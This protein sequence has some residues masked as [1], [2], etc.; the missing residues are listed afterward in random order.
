M[1]RTS[2]SLHLT[3]S[4]TSTTRALN[5]L[6]AN[7]GAPPEAPRTDEQIQAARQ[8]AL[9]EF[10]VLGL[11]SLLGERP[12][13]PMYVELSPTASHRTVH[14]LIDALPPHGPVPPLSIRG[15]IP[16][17]VD[18]DRLNRLFTHPGLLELSLTDVEL[19]TEVLKDIGKALE[20]NHSA[21][22]TLVWTDDRECL[23]DPPFCHI[24]EQLPALRSLA[25]GCSAAD[26]EPD[27]QDAQNWEDLAT[28][29]LSRPLER[30]G[31]NQCGELMQALW[32]SWPQHRPIAWRSL[33]LSHMD[34]GYAEAVFLPHL[35]RFLCRC[36]ADPGLVELHLNR[37]TED[38]NAFDPNIDG[39]SPI[40]LAC[41]Q[42]ADHMAQALKARQ[43]PLHVAVTSDDTAALF[44]IMNGLTGTTEA[45]DT[46]LSE[47]PPPQSE[48]VTCIRSL[49]MTFLVDTNNVDDSDSQEDP[50][51]S[52]L[53]GMSDWLDQLPKLDALHI[54]ME[55]LE[56]GGTAGA[57]PADLT[58]SLVEALDDRKLTRL[59]LTGALFTPLPDA[60]QPTLQKVQA[61]SLHAAL[62]V[63]ALDVCF[64]FLYPPMRFP[65]EIGQ[66]FV[67]HAGD[68]A[69]QRHLVHL[70]PLLN[71]H[72]LIQFVDRYNALAESSNAARHPLSDL[73]DQ[74]R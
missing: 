17:D 1:K 71:Q 31:L 10:N 12:D 35:D 37:F 29:L 47:P 60:L 65:T 8:V 27:T 67:E 52:F 25:I 4:T 32:S 20:L 50:R 18:Q 13:L 56:P 55:P 7:T 69:Q 46:P 42:M 58:Q 54:A 66:A 26:Q 5:P 53:A 23:M 57:W 72:H 28:V 15:P 51:E 33:T 2:S 40:P 61:H 11:R 62:Q 36:I 41:L 9:R 68:E 21:L 63:R 38:E 30:L 70:L 45:L 14:T 3:T 73:A 48:Q 64:D 59:E 24:L 43:A 49:D 34:L 74:M 19:S 16:D 39:D 22:Q 44:N 6:P